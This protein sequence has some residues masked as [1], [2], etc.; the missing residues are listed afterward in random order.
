[1]IAL[2]ICN[3]FWVV[4]YIFI[5]T[6]LAAI[7]ALLAGVRLLLSAYVTQRYLPLVIYITLAI[8][9][10]ASV[11]S[12]QGPLSLLPVIGST[13]LSLSLLRRDNTTLIRAGAGFM[14]LMWAL[15]GFA[16]GSFIEVTANTIALI[17]ILKAF[18]KYDIPQTCARFSRAS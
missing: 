5:G 4:H 12:Y 11:Y 10:I 7:V 16:T 18:I 3:F 15:H 14:C 13:V 17:V 6:T 9:L 1:M 2:G 8:F